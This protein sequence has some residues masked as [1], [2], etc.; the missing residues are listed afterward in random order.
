[1]LARIFISSVQKEF[2]AERRTIRDFVQGDP[3]LRRFFEVFLFEDLPASDRRAD[4]VYLDEV[5]RCA[6]Y[7]GL[8]GQDYG[9]E[10]SSGISP[11][12]REFSR[13]TDLG[14]T[15]LV[16]VKGKDDSGRH[17]KMANLIR[18]AGSQLIRRR[19]ETITDLIAAL[20]TSLVE[21]L[22]RTGGL[23]TKPFDASACPEATM[24]DIADDK[25]KWFLGLARRERQYPLREDTPALEALTHLNLLDAGQPSHAAVLLFARQA[26]RFLITSEVKCMH[27]HGLDIRKPIPS[28]QIYRGTV[29]ELVDQALD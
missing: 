14:K 17:S 1:M 12:E 26:Q 4:D 7:V 13:A 24:A 5:G 16:F 25:V 8:F 29:F 21:Q 19:F 11:T 3:L 9:S 20:Y 10:D 28:Y 23:R 27:F 2:A 15:R 22:E 6:L 18:L